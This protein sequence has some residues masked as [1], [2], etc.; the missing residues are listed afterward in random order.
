MIGVRVYSFR[1][2]GLAFK[3]FNDFKARV[4]A[5]GGVVEANSCLIAALNSLDPK[6]EEL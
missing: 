2:R 5:D 4:L 1:S 3:L 6:K